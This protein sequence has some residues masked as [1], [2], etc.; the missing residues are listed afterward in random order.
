MVVTSY[1]NI[2][3]D[4]ITHAWRDSNSMYGSGQL[5]YNIPIDFINSWLWVEVDVILL[6]MHVLSI[7]HNT[8][9]DGQM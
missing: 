8:N 6:S 9:S 1:Y 2:P 7:C 5:L 3:I 4:F